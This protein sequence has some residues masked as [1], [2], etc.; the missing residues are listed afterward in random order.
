MANSWLEV[1]LLDR[2]ELAYELSLRDTK[3][4]ADDTLEDLVANLQGLILAEAQSTRRTPQ[5]QMNNPG[6]PVNEIVALDALSRLVKAVITCQ[7][8]MRI[9]V[10]LCNSMGDDAM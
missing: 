8:R 4:S 3:V 5:H 7:S 1:S 10:K 2:D 6:E 9:E